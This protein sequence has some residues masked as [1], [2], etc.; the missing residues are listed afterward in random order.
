MARPVTLFTGQWADLPLET[1]AGEDG[2]LGLRRARAR[3]LG[4]SLRGRPRRSPSRGY[5]VEKRVA[6]RAARPELLG[7]R[8]APRRP[9]GLRPDRRAPSERCL[10]PE[11]W[12]DGDPEGVRARAA[13]RMKDTARAAAAFGVDRRERLHRLADLASALLLPAQ[14]LRARSSAA[15]RSSPSAWRRSSTSSTQKACASGSRCIRP[16]SP[17]TSSRPARRSRRSAAGASF[18]INFDPSH[19]V[20][21]VPRPG[22]VRR[23]SSPTASTTC[24]SRT[25]KRALDGRRSILGVAPGLRRARTAAG[26]SS[27]PATAT[28]TSSSSFGR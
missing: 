27:R 9:G 19:F 17:T 5:C 16:R 21:P 15:T 13:E 26:T 28:S 20:P 2:E 14:R 25:R 4:R 11:V 3:L 8:R 18:G 22:R 12:G 24:T 10:P 6:A 1:L 7:D 23:S